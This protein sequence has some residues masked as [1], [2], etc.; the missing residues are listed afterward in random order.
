MLD[1]EYKVGRRW[2]HNLPKV[3]EDD[4]IRRLKRP[5]KG[6][7]IRELKVEMLSKKV[8]SSVCQ[9]VIRSAIQ[10]FD[11]SQQEGESWLNRNKMDE[12]KL[13]A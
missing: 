4:L 3:I 12:K 2:Y 5:I 13:A 10:V 9:R 8:P 6:M 11:I 1:M 7:D